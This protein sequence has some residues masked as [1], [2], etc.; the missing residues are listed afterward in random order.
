MAFPSEGLMRQTMVSLKATA[1]HAS[2]RPRPL[3][4]LMLAALAHHGRL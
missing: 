2:R 1:D 3:E 4:F